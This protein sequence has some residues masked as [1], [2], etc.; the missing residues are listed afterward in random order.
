ME[1]ESQK[2]I[3]YGKNGFDNQFKQCIELTCTVLINNCPYGH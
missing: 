2:T 3:I 1:D